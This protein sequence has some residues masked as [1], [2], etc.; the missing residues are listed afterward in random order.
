MLVN[1]LFKNCRS[2]YQENIFSMQAVKDTELREINTFTVDSRLMPKDENEFIK[3]AVIFGGNASGKSNVL[4]ALAY[5]KNVLLMSASQFPIVAANETFAFYENAQNEEST[6]EVEIIHNA[7]YYKYGF[8][9]LK[10]VV[11]S[12]W[13]ERR[14]ERLTPV[15][16]R[17]DND[18]EITGLSKQATRLINISKNTLFLSVGNN[19]HLDIAPY[20]ND[21]MQWFQNLLIVFENDA[22]I[23][24]IYTMGNG[25]YKEQALKILKLADIGIQDIR[26]KKDK[27]ANMANFNDILNF[28]AQMQINP[29]SFGQLK[30]EEKNLYNIDLETFF[31]VY[32][33]KGRIKG[34][35]DVLLYKNAGFNSEGTARL[36]CYL[37]WI[38]AALDQGRV[39]VIDEIDAKLHFL[40]ADYIIKLFNSIDTNPKNAQLICT[41]HN[42]MLMDEDLR[43][44]Q[45]YFTSKDKYGESSLVSL[46]DYKNV[47]KTD[48][49]SK[50]YLAGFYAKLPDM[51][52][53][54]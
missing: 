5:M 40:V 29:A 52:N 22:N 2:F 11:K 49:F 30:Q 13:L 38:L 46:S 43:R 51:M 53:K 37:G 28:N 50:R 18:L 39:I 48:L 21:V 41:A 6:Y 34:K 1:F 27:V 44:D 4:K 31:V 8:T 45:I 26:V 20:L 24:D 17:T 35:K 12:E 16:K 15:F 23:L 33:E 14:K 25:K 36:L 47:R 7:S 10:G 32:D 54:D 9:L 3:S 42:V 19:F